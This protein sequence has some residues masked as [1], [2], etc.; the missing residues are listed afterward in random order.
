MGETKK[1]PLILDGD[2]GH[3]DAIAWM[4]AKANPALDIR[5]VTSCAGNQTIEKTTYNARRVCTLLGIDAPVAMGRPRPLLA[6]PITAGNI[7]G[8]T[9]LDGPALPEPAME[10]SP[11]GAVELMAKVLR[12]SEEPVTIVSTGPQTNVAALLLA[13]PE[14]KEKIGRIS[15][16]GG[17]IAYGNWTP[18]AE[19]N[20]LVDPEAAQTVF[21]SGVPV[22]MAGLDV[23]EKA[24]IFPE[25]FERIRAVGNQVAQVV[26]EWLEFFYRFHRSIGYAGAP[27]HDPCAVA[28]LLR[29]ELFTI[30][31]L[32]VEVETA[33]E[34]CRG[35]TVGDVRGRTGRPANA[36]CLMNVDRQ[37]FAELLV[38]AVRAYDGWEVRV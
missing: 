15:L 36:R 27:V 22:N 35:T 2:P 31:E 14:L 17:G 38:E 32:Y 18:A 28:V 1:I 30:Q 7:H 26:A 13:H 37:G 34:Y 20:I 9:G 25:D 6:D 12:E 29:P 5:A 11:I 24:L 4:L 21:S 19:F 10:V 16:M 33:G 3:D 8:Q 23:T